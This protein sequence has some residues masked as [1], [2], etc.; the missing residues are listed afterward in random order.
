MSRLVKYPKNGLTTF[1]KIMLDDAHSHK[2]VS[3]D[4]PTG[5]GC[6]DAFLHY[7]LN[8]PYNFDINPSQR[9]MITT[10]SRE[11]SYALENTVVKEVGYGYNI[12]FM[13]FAN[14]FVSH[15]DSPFF[16]L[17]IVHEINFPLEV[18]EKFISARSNFPKSQL[19]LLN[20]SW[21]IGNV[22]AG[23]FKNIKYTA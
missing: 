3:I 17:V 11:Q 15:K 10:F 19:I 14:F 21:P 13:T 8:Y 12:D 4:A 16:S 7:A 2:M 6:G 23:K 9:I 5:S 20:C 22:H 1:Q 18:F